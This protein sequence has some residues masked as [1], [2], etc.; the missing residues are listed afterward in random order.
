M[1]IQII[2]TLNSSMNEGVSNVTKHFIENIKPDN[3]IRICSLKKSIFCLKSISKSDCVLVFSK[4]NQKAYKLLKFLTLFNKKIF[5]MVLQPCESGFSILYNKRPLSCY[6]FYLSKNDLNLINGSISCANSFPFSVG[7]DFTKFCPVTEEMQ[8]ALKEKY[9]FSINNKIVLHVGHCTEGRGLLDFLKINNSK[10][11][12]L[13]IDSGMYENERIT[14]TLKENGVVV[15][16]GYQPNIEEFY[17]L[18]DLY[19]FPTADAKFVIS[20]PL[21]VIEAL[22][23]GTPVLLNNAFRYLIENGNIDKRYIQTFDKEPKV[24][25]SLLDIK[26]E[27]KI[28]LIRKNSWASVVNACL[29]KIK[30]LVYEN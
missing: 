1:K 4:L 10:W 3:E 24:D 2:S 29:L 23:C 12:K 13:F 14:S 17:Q 8:I 19:F 11:T 9:N 21:S 7:V 18:A 25:D 6:F 15:I 27:F 28:G 30:E 20:Q 5:L 16:S 26:K 22:A